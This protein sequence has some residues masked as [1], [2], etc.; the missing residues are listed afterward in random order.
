MPKIE[1]EYSLYADDITWYLA[2]AYLKDHQK[3]K[4]IEL[5][6]DIVKNDSESE[7]GKKAEALLKEIE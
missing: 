7:L 4:T 2:L 3:D 1:Y 5:L 6:K